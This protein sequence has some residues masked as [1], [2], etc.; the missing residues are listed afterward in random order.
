MKL[1]IFKESVSYADSYTALRMREYSGLFEFVSP[2]NDISL[3][4]ES[5]LSMDDK[6]EHAAAKLLFDI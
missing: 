4:I 2:G 6:K 3:F 5:V 1:K